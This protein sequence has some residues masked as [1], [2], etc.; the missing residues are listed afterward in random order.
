MVLANNVAN[1]VADGARTV[2]MRGIAPAVALLVLVATSSCGNTATATATAAESRG[3]PNAC[4]L[5]VHPAAAK[6]FANGVADAPQV[7]N[8]PDGSSQSCTV[9][10][11]SG[12]NDYHLVLTTALNGNNAEAQLCKGASV[13]R[14]TGIGSAACWNP[15]TLTAAAWASGRLVAVA[16]LTPDYAATLRGPLLS[17]LTSMVAEVSSHP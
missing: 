2:T 4:A 13:Q 12:V 17:L 16:S 15:D 8:G 10:I 7:L 5:L 3:L 6:A 14:I 11:H 9:V 1:T